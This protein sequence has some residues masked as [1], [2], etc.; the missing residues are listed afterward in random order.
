MEAASIK[1]KM[2]L[3][4]KGGLLCLVTVDLDMV[5]ADAVTVDSVMVLAVLP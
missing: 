2:Y 4:L 3:I 1:K 5:M